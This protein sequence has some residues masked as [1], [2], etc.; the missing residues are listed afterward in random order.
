[1]S[2][3][4]SPSPDWSPAG[5]L[6]PGGSRP[7]EKGAAGKEETDGDCTNPSSLLAAADSF[8]HCQAGCA[9]VP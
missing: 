3:M 8:V 6:R 1:M 4:G 2:A 9:P 7:Q 5:K